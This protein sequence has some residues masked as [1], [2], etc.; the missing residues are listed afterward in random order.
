M[1]RKIIQ[2][3]TSGVE[4]TQ[5]TQADFILTAL[6]NDGTIWNRFGHQSNWLRVEDIPQDILRRDIPETPPTTTQKGG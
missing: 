6:C 3:C 1:T 2:I 5:G 4:N